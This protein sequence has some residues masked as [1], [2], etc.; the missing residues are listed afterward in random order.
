[1]FSCESDSG[2]IKAGGSLN[3]SS[4]SQAYVNYLEEGLH[5]LC[6]LAHLLYLLFQAG[7]VPITCVDNGAGKRQ[8]WAW[9]GLECK[10]NIFQICHTHLN[11]LRCTLHVRYI[12][13]CFQNC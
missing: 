4:E 6:A 11:I 9:T 13:D 12:L 5:L 2:K 3:R 8:I 10:S 7:I 1:M